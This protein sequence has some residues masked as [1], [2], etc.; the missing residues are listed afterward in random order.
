VHRRLSPA[1]QRNGGTVTAGNSS[2][3]SD[4]AAALVLASAAAVARLGLTPIARIRGWGEAA[5]A[6]ER[7]TTAPALA[8]P[9]ALAAARVTAAQVDAYEI[10]EAFSVVALANEALLSLDPARVNAHGGAVALGHPIGA[11]G[12]RIVVTLLSVLARGGG[13]LG[14]AAICNGGGGASALVVERMPTARL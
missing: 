11:S 13:S 14:V 12:A 7:F 9:K 8:I 2:G 3:V 1:F 6:P 5:H 10:N 4:G